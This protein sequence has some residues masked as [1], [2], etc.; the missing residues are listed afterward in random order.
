V[1]IWFSLLNQILFT[2]Y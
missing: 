1:S 2:T